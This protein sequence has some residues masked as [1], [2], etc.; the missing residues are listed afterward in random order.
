MA[1]SGSTPYNFSANVLLIFFLLDKNKTWF[2]ANILA[3]I[4]T[5]WGWKHR[6]PTNPALAFSTRCA[7]TRQTSGD[8]H[9]IY[10]HVGI[11][12]HGRTGSS[13]HPQEHG[14]RSNRSNSIEPDWSPAIERQRLREAWQRVQ[15]LAHRWRGRWRRI[16]WRR[17]SWAIIASVK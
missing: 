16:W 2:S 17:G 8:H 6:Y 1:F 5:E 3:E 13:F 7:L 9:I 12:A 4:D 10:A 11:P 15:A 14:Q